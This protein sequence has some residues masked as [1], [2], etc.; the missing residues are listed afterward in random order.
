MA[1]DLMLSKD[2]VEKSITG[3]LQPVIDA[4]IPFALVFGNHDGQGI[5]SNEEQM[6]FYRTFPGCL[7][8]KGECLTGVGNYNL[9]LTDHTGEK[10]ILNLWFFDSGSYAKVNGE[11]SYACV[12]KDQLDWY[13]DASQKIT[14]ENNGEIVPAFVFQHIPVPEIY[15][16]LTEVDEGT[17]GAVSKNG[18]SYILNE[19]ATTDGNFKELPCS[20]LYNTGEFESWKE[21]GDVITAFFGHDHVNDF[22][23]IYDGIKMTYIP[24]CGFYAYGDGY[25]RGIRV[26]ELDE[27]DIT[28]YTS[29][30]IH[31]SDISSE[32]ISNEKALFDG[33]VVHGKSLLSYITI[34][35]ILPL[36]VISL[37]CVFIIR[38][39][40][41]H[42]SNRKSRNNK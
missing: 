5:M 42:T 3:F 33:Y 40:R 10:N 38:K 17:I 26:L 29:H 41:K 27:T 21:A 12:A 39:V 4:N 32:K 14:K 11:K 13:L 16:C 37:L 20:P 35:A 6:G 23:G 31:F 7:A 25:N 2:N 8:Q 22:S 19:E 18:K 1:P 36:T 24:G 30:I 15:N 9:M 28:N 34:F